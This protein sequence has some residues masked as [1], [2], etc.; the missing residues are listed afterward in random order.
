MERF[1]K[2]NPR[3]FIGE[4]P[5]GDRGWCA[6]LLPATTT[7]TGDTIE[8]NYSFYSLNGVY[9][10]SSKNPLNDKM[11]PNDLIKIIQ[12]FMGRE[13]RDR[14]LL[15][16][17]DFSNKDAIQGIG[18]NLRGDL[19]D[20]ATATISSS[21]TLHWAKGCTVSYDADRKCISIKGQGGQEKPMGIAK[22]YPSGK[23]FIFQET[24]LPLDGAGKGCLELGCLEFDIAISLNSD[25][26]ELDFG[27]RYFAYDPLNEKV[28]SQRYPLL[29][30]ADPL[31]WPAG[32]DVRLNV[33]M[34]PTSNL[35][36]NR[37]FWAFA[38]ADPPDPP[39][40]SAFVTTMGQRILLT[41]VTADCPSSSAPARMVFAR[42]SDA[43]DDDFYL[44][45]QGDFVM[46]VVEPA[47]DGTTCS[48]LC[49]LEGTEFVV[50]SSGNRLRF[51]AGQPAYAADFPLDKASVP[52]RD[53]LLESKLTTSWIT[54]I[55]GI[56]GSFHSPS[57]DSLPIPRYNM[58]PEGAS[59]YTDPKNGCLKFYETGAA[60]PNKNDFCFPMAPYTMLRID[61]DSSI[62]SQ[63]GIKDFESSILRPARKG[64]ILRGHDW[65]G[66][67]NP[68]SC[69]TPQGFIFKVK[70]NGSYAEVCL[71]QTEE[72]EV[73]SF[74]DPQP[75]L[76]DA[77]Q[78]DQL[79]LVV[80]ENALLGKLVD[81]QSGKG[82]TGSKFYN[83]ISLGGWRFRANVPEIGVPDDSGD[84]RNVMIFK[85]CRGK[86]ADLVQS[87]GCWT[88]P[89]AFNRPDQLSSISSWLKSY[90]ED[91]TDNHK[92]D[93]NF[94]K[95]QK[96]VVNENWNGVLFLRVDI[97]SVP[98]QMSGI[99]SGIDKDRLSAH[100]LGIEM[101]LVDA[102]QVIM[103]PDSLSSAFGL[104]YYSYPGYAGESIAPPNGVD[105]HFQVLTLQALF[106]SSAVKDFES[107]AQLTINRIFNHT[108]LRA[109]DSQYNSLMFR[110]SCQ[111]ESG[112]TTYILDMIGDSSLYLSSSVLR[113]VELVKAQMSTRSI[114]ELPVGLAEGEV[115]Q[116]ITSRFDFWGFMDFGLLKSRAKE[117]ADGIEPSKIFDIF[118]FGSSDGGNEPRSGLSFSGL[119]LNMTDETTPGAVPRF[120][121]DLSKLAFDIS[122]S[123]PRPDSIY[124]D[125]SLVL[126]GLIGGDEKSKPEDAGYLVVQTGNSGPDLSGLCGPWSGLQ[127]R[128]NM[129]TPGELAGKAGLQSTL[130][131]AWS[132]GGADDP[133]SYNALVG[134]KLPGS[135]GVSLFDIQGILKL[136]IGDVRLICVDAKDQGGKERRSFMLVL[137]EIALKVLGLL[138]IPPTGATSFYLFGNP[139]AGGKASE[140]GWYAIYNKTVANV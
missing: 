123:T 17:K 139:N 5:V 81:A 47:S 8:L 24:R 117:A 58:Q 85:F 23:D 54:I 75:Q 63:V 44:A 80:T 106:E 109:S 21:L 115:Y 120:S 4:L 119:G 65:T 1:T 135:S 134:V 16:S 26:D 62:F 108:V 50:L 40:P 22:D 73:V 64:E 86:L 84:Y 11:K 90:I 98:E 89:E 3:L 32:R 69:A 15:W 122:K 79:F 136:S 68:I 6:Y 55:S 107:L 38:R 137:T 105:Y 48:L 74:I 53:E 31:H 19:T 30:P 12:N 7:Y 92:T 70:D 82:I 28:C 87:P 45:A 59:L 103:R 110:G 57:N 132:D 127:F 118:S 67:T 37:S 34:D 39:L 102:S 94:D 96:I 66:G 93:K 10:F 99:L 13:N 91:A 88:N 27:I 101:N 130:L 77:L 51:I 60:L 126:E 71:A 116:R 104:I 133:E 95:F 29:C 76:Q 128:L 25:F 121:Q 112:N 125:F 9:L 2:I 111:H 43:P 35:D 140:L 113:R 138:K 52:K 61:P 100:H 131:M 42:K 124:S 18:F 33:R 72:K 97:T 78:T 83:V 129:G 56:S 46:T 49:G 14:Y 36:P 114:E 41:P 20:N